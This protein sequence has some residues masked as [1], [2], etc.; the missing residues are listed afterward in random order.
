MF[1]CYIFLAGVYISG[2]SIFLGSPVLHAFTLRRRAKRG[3][4]VADAVLVPLVVS[5]IHHPNPALQQHAAPVV[6]DGESE[7]GTSALFATVIVS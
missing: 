3:R 5:H 4:A 7:F 6:A 1:L 2:E